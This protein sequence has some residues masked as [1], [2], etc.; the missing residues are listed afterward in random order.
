MQKFK[1]TR[2]GVRLIKVLLALIEN[3]YGYT[4]QQLADLYN[5]HADTIKQDIED[6]RD[7]GFEVKPDKKYRYGILKN[8]FYE[9][10][11]ELLFFTEKEQNFMLEA[12]GKMNHADK[13][14]DKVRNKL[15]TIY[16]ISKLGSSIISKPFLTKISILEKAKA[17][18][19]LVK[20]IAYRSTNSGEET[21]R[22]I[23]A[24]H[25]S[26]HEDM[27]HAF[28]V[29]RKGIRHFRLSR[30]D[31]VEIIEVAWNYEGKH[32]VQAT[33]PFRIVDDKQVKV[34]VRMRMMGLN[35]LVERFPLAQA[36]IRPA[37]D[38]ENIYELECKVNHRF[39]GI[40]AFILS[41]HSAIVE[42][43]EP[44]S[45]IDHINQEAEKIKF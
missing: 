41:N 40:T 12:L 26:P 7:A 29:E 18:K 22:L 35:E 38:I 27:L 45:L 9:H 3:P 43:V 42:I 37:A 6:I 8:K 28:D 5:V 31:R 17:N 19:H 14:Y 15:Q 25:I 2:S 39:Y 33:D 36:Y 30:F 10:L 44:E 20:L 21:D 11:E 34:H 24:F 1:D 13:R 16:D 4:K 23:E 32:Y